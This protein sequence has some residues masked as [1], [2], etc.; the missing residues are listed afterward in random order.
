MGSSLT[1]YNWKFAEGQQRTTAEVIG[2]FYRAIRT[3][4][5]DSLVIGCNTV[6][7]L[8]AG[9]FEICRI[10]DDTS[11]EEWIRVPQMGVNALAFRAVQQGAFYVADPDCVGVTT[12]ILWTL[13]RQWLDLVSR[14]GTTT[15]VS[16]AP[17]ALGEQ[18]RSDLRDALSRAAQPQPLGEPLDWM[19]TESPRRWRL[20]G[21]T[22]RYDWTG[23]GGLSAPS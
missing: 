13:N 22:E 5:A 3:A 21:K 2:E 18:Q 6:S 10:G 23:A 11:G 4:A 17:D 1:N 7:H 14:S 12:K 8:S 20:M 15:F 16:I 9:L 19:E